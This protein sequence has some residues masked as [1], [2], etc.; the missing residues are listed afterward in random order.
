MN[1]ARTLLHARRRAALTQR[2]LAG[3]SGVA[4]PTIARIELGAERP[5]V[6]TLVR[7][8]R[9]CGESLEALPGAGAGVDRTPIRALLGLSPAE[10]LAT[11]AAEAPVFERLA[12][13]R[14]VP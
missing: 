4:Q 8:L 12:A 6:D 3:R 7:L 14:R 13:A 11:L 1:A 5:R 9:V 2:E 10:R